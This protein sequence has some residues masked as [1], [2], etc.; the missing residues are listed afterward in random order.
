MNK[1]KTSY[2]IKC[3]EVFLLTLNFATLKLLER[4]VTHRSKYISDIFRILTSSKIIQIINLVHNRLILS[5][6]YKKA[7]LIF[8]QLHSPLI[9]K[10][11]K[12][13]VS[14]Y[15]AKQQGMGEI[16]HFKQRGMFVM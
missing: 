15:T 8:I 7:Y 11:I 12:N 5:L 1:L 16:F 6:M 2:T 3:N 9:K 13:V 4:N 14:E 10:N